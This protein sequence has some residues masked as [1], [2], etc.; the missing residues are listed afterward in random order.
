MKRVLFLLFV[1]FTTIDSASAHPDILSTYPSMHAPESREELK[2]FYQE[3]FILS[4][5]STIVIVMT[6]TVSVVYREELIRHIVR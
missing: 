5:I 6:I 4:L 3:Y 1:S 2:T